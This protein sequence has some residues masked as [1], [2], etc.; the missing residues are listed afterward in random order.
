MTNIQYNLEFGNDF[1]LQ[2]PRIPQEVLPKVYHVLLGMARP[3]QIPT[4]CLPAMPKSLQEVWASPT[5][6]TA[7]IFLSSDPLLACHRASAAK[8]KPSLLLQHCPRAW[9][10]QVTILFLPL[11]QITY[12]PFLH[13]A[14]GIVKSTHCQIKL[15]LALMTTQVD[16]VTGVLLTLHSF[17]LF[18]V[19]PLNLTA[20]S[21]NISFQMA[22]AASD[23]TS[24]ST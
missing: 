7:I 6:P 5:Y 13:L 15:A 12:I 4:P 16:W 1:C 19:Q 14:T 17:S 18:W 23:M 24:P 8:H 22:T 2:K 10:V 20:F 11:K 21:T 3:C 9:S